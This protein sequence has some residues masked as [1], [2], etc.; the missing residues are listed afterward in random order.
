MGTRFPT[1]MAKRYVTKPNDRDTPNHL[2]KP[3]I[4]PEPLEQGGTGGISVFI[5]PQNSGFVKVSKIKEEKCCFKTPVRHIIRQ[6]VTQRSARSE[7]F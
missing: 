7:P 4:P 2:I 3:K 5:V 1:G 6:A